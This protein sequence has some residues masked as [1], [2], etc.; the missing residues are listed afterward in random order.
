MIPGCSR[1]WRRTSKT[2]APAARVTALIARP[3]KRKTT[4]APAEITVARLRD[5][6]V[7]YTT[8]DR[9]EIR[10]GLAEGDQV[11]TVGRA[12]VRDGTAVTV[13]EAAK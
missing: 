12:A 1:N 8:G 9:V 4:A 11:I 13:L 3:E 2:M 5:V 6:K 10:E 7:G